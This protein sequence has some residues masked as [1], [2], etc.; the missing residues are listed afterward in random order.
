MIWKITTKAHVIGNQRN[1]TD[2]SS[3]QISLT[4]Y[5][6]LDAQKATSPKC[7]IFP[8]KTIMEYIPI[9]NLPPL[10]SQTWLKGGCKLLW[11][12]FNSPPFWFIFPAFMSITCTYSCNHGNM[13]MLI[14]IMQGKSFMI[15]NLMNLLSVK[16]IWKQV[17]ILN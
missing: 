3:G 13:L 5:T 6:C 7:T 11:A 8:L 9:T 15:L 14:N 12:S 10:L 17:E 4:H 1:H 2:P 16:N